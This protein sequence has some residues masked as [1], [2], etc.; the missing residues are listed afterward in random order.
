MAINYIKSHRT[1]RFPTQ[2]SKR[3]PITPEQ[4]IKS[5][6][7]HPNLLKDTQRS[8]YGSTFIRHSHV[9]ISLVLKLNGLY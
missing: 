4:T 5:H 1:P 2:R 3:K 6:L 8:F 7:F 9:N